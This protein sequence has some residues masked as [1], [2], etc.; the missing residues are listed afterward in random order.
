MFM[1]II[2]V[3]PWLFNIAIEMTHLYMNVYDFP[4]KTSIDSGF[5]M[6]MLNKQMVMGIIDMTT[7]VITNNHH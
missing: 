6:A 1:G 7:N 2:N 3:T 4:M 5:S